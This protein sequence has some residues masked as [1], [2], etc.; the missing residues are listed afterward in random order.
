VPHG[1]ELAGSKVPKVIKDIAKKTKR[2]TGCASKK[3]PPG[4]V[5][6]WEITPVYKGQPGKQAKA[7]LRYA[8]GSV[9]GQKRSAVW[10]QKVY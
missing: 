4:V 3:H 10:R 2:Q 9:A 5:R 6:A 8:G 1:N 7:R